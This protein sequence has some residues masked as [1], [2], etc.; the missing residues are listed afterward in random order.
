MPMAWLNIE[1]M[2]GKL[3]QY[4]TPGLLRFQTSAAYVKSVAGVDHRTWK[5]AIAW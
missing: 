1:A 3:S 4:L 5:P 2:H